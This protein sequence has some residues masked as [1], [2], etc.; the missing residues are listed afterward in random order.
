MR[1]RKEQT[2]N[3]MQE[4][5]PNKTQK[6]RAQKHNTMIIQ[7]CKIKKMR[8]QKNNNLNAGVHEEKETEEEATTEVRKEE[9]REG[10]TTI[11]PKS[12]EQTA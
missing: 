3:T 10:V 6:R 9:T 8:I 1:K 2:C 5:N 4:Y 11:V 7:E 12:Q